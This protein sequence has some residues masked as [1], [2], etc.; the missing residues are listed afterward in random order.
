MGTVADTYN[1]YQQFLDE[2]QYNENGVKRYEWIFGD[3]Y[4]STGGL[5]TTKMVV[6]FLELK[7]GYKVF[8]FGSGIGGH[9]FYM[10]KTYDVYIDACDLSQNMMNVALNYYNQMPEVKD[11]INFRLCDVM[12]TEFPENYYD[13]I[14]SR[15]ALLHIKDKPFLFKKFLRLLKP[16]GKI[17]FTDYIRGSSEASQEFLDYLKSRDYTLQTTEEYEK[18][19]REAGFEKVSIN[20]AKNSFIESLDRELNK[21]RTGKEEFLSKFSQKDYDD[22]EQGWVA[23][24]KRA[25]DGNQSWG[26]GIGYKPLN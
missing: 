4:L 18:I 12:T 22:L 23:K 10:V 5:E 3:G 14:Y 15:D 11:K 21:L 26:I 2:V 7:P 9:D 25:A 16:G 6:P 20:D 1:K 17:V 19:M 13:V 8:D 24:I